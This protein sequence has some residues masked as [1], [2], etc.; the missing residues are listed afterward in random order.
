MSFAAEFESIA[1][2]LRE[3]ASQIAAGVEGSFADE[4]N[5]HPMAVPMRR[6]QRQCLRKAFEL[7]RLA[8][9]VRTQRGTKRR[10]SPP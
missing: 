5:Q 8:Q 4:E 3:A 10:K 7:E 2:I 6:A 1:K 9:A